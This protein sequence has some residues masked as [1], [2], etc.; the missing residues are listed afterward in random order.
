MKREEGM[1]R[2]RS[3]G[4]AG[5]KR[6]WWERVEEGLPHLKDSTFDSL[7]ELGDHQKAKVKWLTS[8]LLH[9]FP[10]SPHPDLLE[11][12]SPSLPC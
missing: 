6:A 12:Q 7:E 2:S 11:P 10:P 5:V 1:S 3:R 8:S 9:F 4:A